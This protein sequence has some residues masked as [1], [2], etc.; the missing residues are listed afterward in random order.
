MRPQL[1]GG[2]DNTGNSP[3]SDVVVS[4]NVEFTK[5]PENSKIFS[6]DGEKRIPHVL[7]KSHDSNVYFELESF[8]FD[9]GHLEMIRRQEMRMAVLVSMVYTDVFDTPIT[10]KPVTYWGAPQVHENR[11]TRIEC[12]LGRRL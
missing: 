10:T 12:S 4:I 11:D 1:F 3:A 6:V 9:D 2:L 5:L 7:S 8:N